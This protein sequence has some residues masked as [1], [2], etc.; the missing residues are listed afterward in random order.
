MHMVVF[1]TAEGKTAYHPTESLEDAVKFVE[2]VTN[3]EGVSD[4]RVF[5]MTEIPLEVKAIYKVEVAG[6]PVS[7]AE[8]S[9]QAL[10]QFSQAG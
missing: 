10:P 3:S 4:A 7:V 8:S 1:T 2:R 5:Q 6:V 9:A